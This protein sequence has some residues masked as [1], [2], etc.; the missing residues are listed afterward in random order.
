MSSPIISKELQAGI[1]QAQELAKAMHHEY[2]TLE[3]LLLA[4]LSAPGCTEALRACGVQMS[5]LSKRLT[6]FLEESVEQL[7]PHSK[8]EPQHTIGVERVLQRAALHALSA[9]QKYMDGM[10]VIIAMFREEDSFALYSLEEEGLTRLT[11]LNYVSHGI[12]PE[13]PPSMEGEE[14]EPKTPPSPP[15]KAIAWTCSPRPKPAAWTLSSA[16]ARS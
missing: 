15:W 9:E 10:D 13:S 5:R 12:S 7:P 8:R 4:L 3:H 2:L 16:A 14:E 11:L 6:A 1:R